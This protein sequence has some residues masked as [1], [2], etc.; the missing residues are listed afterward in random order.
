MKRATM[1]MGLGVLL[2]TGTG[3]AQ[4]SSY[5][6]FRVGGYGEMVAKF[7]D[8]GTNRFYGGTDNSDHRNTIS[9][10][11]FVLAMDYRFTPKWLLGAE[12]EFESGGVGIE[13]ELENSENGEYETELERGGEVALEQFHIT[14]LVHRSFNVRAGHLIVPVG[15]TNAHH[16]PI[17]FFGT[18]RPEGESTLLPCTWHETGLEIF[19][20]IG[21]G[22]ATFDYQVLVVAGMNADGFGRDHWVQGGRQ[23]LFEEDNFT[24]PGYVVRVDYR[25][26]EGLRVGVSAYYCHDVTANADKPYKYSTVGRSGL[27]IGSATIRKTKGKCGRKR[28]VSAKNR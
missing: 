26:L 13:S 11:R 22:C 16:E 3:R 27:F 18:S 20:T 25:G 6:K 21:S 5:E 12:I 8:Y 7:M 1:L 10:P 2:A 24:S 19:G 17:H 28:S 14:R 15:L 4:D 23:G 9:I